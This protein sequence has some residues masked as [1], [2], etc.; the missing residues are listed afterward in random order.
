MTMIN[1]M[2]VI[3]LDLLG[4]ESRLPGIA[5]WYEPDDFYAAPREEP[6]LVAT[7]LMYGRVHSVLILASQSRWLRDVP[8]HCFRTYWD[9]IPA[10]QAW[11]RQTHLSVLSRRLP[12][13]IDRDR[14]EEATT[15]P[16]YERLETLGDMYLKLETSWYLYHVR[17]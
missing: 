16:L 15:R 17:R 11:E 5:R 4:H 10:L 14:L 6:L 12:V 3:G 9:L 2:M 1:L 8:S 7:K 13:P